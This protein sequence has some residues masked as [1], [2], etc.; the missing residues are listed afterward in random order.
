MHV[1]STR[2]ALVVAFVLAVA[3]T[4]AA[5]RIQSA[6][7]VPF[8]VHEWGTFTSIAG[9]DGQA[10]QW[11]PQ[12]G[13]SDLPCFVER[14]VFNIKGS[15]SGT[16]R[17]E[18]PVLYFYAARDVTVNVKVGFK[19]GVITEWYPRALAGVPDL[20]R[21]VYEGTID[22]PHVRV[23]PS[24]EPLFP[25]EP[26]RSHYY[27]AR[28]TGATPVQV[29]PQREK[30]LFYRGVG[31]FAPPISARVD[32]D[33]RA[34]V[35]SSPGDAIGDVILFENRSG[36]ISYSVQHAS[37]GRL[38]LAPPALDDESTPPSRELVRILMAHGLYQ[39]EAEAMVETW[40]DSWFEEGV[41]L[42]Y[43]VPRAAVDALVPLTITPAPAS[44]ARVFVGRMELVTAA[45][46]QDVRR[47]LLA[48]DGA[49]LAKY[50]RFLGPIGQRVIAESTQSERALLEARL[51]AYSSAWMVP[52]T[53]CR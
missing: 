25:M 1:R 19:Q 23:S 14:S 42:F 24:L 31:R 29:G 45:T 34:V 11:L 43:V 16:V 15:L 28:A 21:P 5:T 33:G 36:A 10:L 3:A 13:A 26:G 8:T 30:F 7:P 51:Q 12:G 52:A 22:W 38:T 17:M 2:V 32:A 41:R 49:V 6:D 9:E 53:S 27:T 47:G 18:T 35:W 4:L 37:G 40:S 48:A 46:R 20:R 44:V 39:Q 50:G